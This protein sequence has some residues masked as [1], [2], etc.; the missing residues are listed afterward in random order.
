MKEILGTQY[1]TEKEASKRYGYSMAWFSKRRY[2]DL[3][4]KYV[5]RENSNRVLYPVKE[6]D[7]WFRSNL[8]SSE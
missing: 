6:T 3:P 1:L 4:P 8:Q 7:D 2:K 5:T